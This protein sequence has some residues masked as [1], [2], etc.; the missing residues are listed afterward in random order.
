MMFFSLEFHDFSLTE[1][2]KILFDNK[3][4]LFG[5]VNGE[6]RIRDLYNDNLIYANVNVDQW[7]VNR[8]TL[9]ILDLNSRWD[10]SNSALEISM[11]N[12]MKER[13]PI[14]VFGYYKPLRIV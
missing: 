14:G 12:R 13:T 5:Q 8:D 6:V 10:A 7:G 11:V 2:N 3:L 1:F 9:G 4:Q